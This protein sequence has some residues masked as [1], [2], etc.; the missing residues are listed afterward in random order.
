MRP[1]LRGR[2]ATSAPRTNNVIACTT[3][4]LEEACRRPR[5]IRDRT[6]NHPP[7]LPKIPPSARRRSQNRPSRDTDEDNSWLELGS[8]PVTG[9]VIGN[10][11]IEGRIVILTLTITGH[12]IEHSDSDIFFEIPR[13][14]T[15]ALSKRAGVSA[16]PTTRT[17]T[18]ARV[19]ILKKLR[20]FEHEVSN[21]YC[22]IQAN[23]VDL[24]NL[25]KSTD[26]DEW[27]TVTVLEAAERVLRRPPNTL[28]SLF[29]T[30]RYLMKRSEEF[31]P[32]VSTHRTAQTFDVRPQ[33]HLEKLKA[34]RDMI[35]DGNPA[36]D[37]FATKARAIMTANRKRRMES[38]HEP[39]TQEV[40]RDIAYTRED[41]L[42]IDVLQHALRRYR[43]VAADPY[44]L[45]TSTVLKKLQV[46]ADVMDTV[47]LREA[48][49]DLGHL[50]PWEDMVSRRNELK[51][52]QLPDEESPR[53]I[54]QNR[55]VERNLSRTSIAGST[56]PLGE[57]D[58][59]PRDPVEHLRHDFG[60]MPVYVVD[61]M[62]AEELD[63]GLS[64]EEVPSEPGSVWVHVHIADPTALLP[65]THVFAQQA[66]EMG[67]TRYFTHRTWPMLPVSLTQ[68][69]LSLGVGC[70]V[71]QP[72][73][74]LTF[75][76]KVNA[77]GNMVDYDVRAGLIRNVRTVDYDSLDHILR[78]PNPA[79]PS[80]P[81]DSNDQPRPSSKATLQPRDVQNLHLLSETITRHRLYNLKLSNA[82]VAVLP[83]A[84]TSVIDKPLYT[85]PLHSPDSFYFRGFPIIHYKVLFQKIQEVGSRMIV[86]E[87]MKAACRVASRWF[88]DRHVPML[89]R[90]SKPP[91]PLGDPN[92]FSKILEAR[93]SDGFVDFYLAQQANLHIPPVEHT[94]EPDMHWSMGIPNGEGY[95]RVTSPLRRYNDLVAHWQIKH[96][97]LHPGGHPFF[98]Q[99]WLLNYAPEIKAKERLL[100][101]AE[102]T[103]YAYW[104][105][106]YIKRFIEDPNAAKDRQDPLTSLTANIVST[107]FVEHL[108]STVRTLCHIPSLGLTATLT[109]PS[110][111]ILNVGD[112]VDV[113]IADVQVGLRPRIQVLPK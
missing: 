65:P 76:F 14:I 30:H 99:E 103:H 24:Y 86:A 106:L 11:L 51:L 95:V 63:D 23:N 49:I 39:P 43:E 75:S 66:H 68:S 46:Q 18:S 50:A 2:V 12:T 20:D 94:L 83:Y 32:Q 56:H 22:G 111:T 91:V 25:V 84:R 10:A 52:D 15:Y 101:E 67:F 62:G 27:S 31:V 61:D 109:A 19:A 104:T 8:T 60:E 3:K 112:S 80:R 64:V 28:A 78:T 113:R 81:F 59:Y 102:R 5:D 74:V 53:V 77:A 72:E 82:F 33:N 93:D 90:T 47:A 98:S 42:I 48:L 37:A 55:I 7:E 96:A 57:E 17:E 6:F 44:S 41:R 38:W 97:L 4:I 34:V 45:V 92:A 100:K 105:A 21:A 71:G 70:K 110:G 54:A 13:M 69:K 107:N 89:R 29:A 1:S 58:F 79:R 40:A 73:Q 87:C 85:T 16:M 88:T 9:I 26:P 35:H 36:I 108:G